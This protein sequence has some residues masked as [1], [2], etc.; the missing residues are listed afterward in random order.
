[1]FRDWITNRP[2]NYLEEAQKP[3]CFWKQI[4][5]KLIDFKKISKNSD[6][7]KCNN[8]GSQLGLLIIRL[9]PS[10]QKQIYK[11]AKTWNNFT[12]SHCARHFSYEIISAR[13]VY[14]HFLHIL[15]SKSLP[16]KNITWHDNKKIPRNW[17]VMK[18]RKFFYEIRGR[19]NQ[20]QR[21]TKRATYKKM[22]ETTQVFATSN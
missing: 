13:T 10:K 19:S 6:G 12:R 1:M 9:S 14:R 5:S 18:S 17:T 20:S 2:K 16:S 15:T 11:E 7:L 8:S 22:R 21:I 4:F 3:N